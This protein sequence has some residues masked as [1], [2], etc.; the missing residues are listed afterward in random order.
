MLRDYLLVIKINNKL[1]F[2]VK[3]LHYQDIHA[4]VK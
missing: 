3:H 1:H 4:F 2:I